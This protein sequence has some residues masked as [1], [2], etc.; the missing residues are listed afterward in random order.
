MGDI[1]FQIYGFYGLKH[2]AVEIS[3]DVTDAGRTDRRTNNKGIANQLPIRETLSFA[4]GAIW[5]N[6]PEKVLLEIN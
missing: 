4:M 1:R 6:Q 3:E 2:H 5:I